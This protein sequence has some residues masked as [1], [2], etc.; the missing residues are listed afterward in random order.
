MLSVLIVGCGNIAGRFD[1]G[2][3]SAEWPVTHA[4]AYRKDG[5]FALA[6]CVDP[7]IARRQDFMSAWSIREGYGSVTE[8][9]KSGK[10]FDVVSICTPTSQHASDLETALALEP[11]AVFCEKPI[12]PSVEESEGIVRRYAE[13]G[14][15][16]G[17]N[18]NRRW[19]PTI[20]GLRD[21]IAQGGWG[22]LRSATAVYNKGL[23]NN[24]SH[25]LDLLSQL[26][27]PLEPIA[28]GPAISDFFETDP[29]IPACLIE[30][31]GAPIYLTCSHAADYSLFEFRLVFSEGSVSIE[32][33][34]ERWR[35]RRVMDSRRFAGY[36]VLDAGEFHDG[37][38]EKTMSLAVDN[39]YR[40][41]AAN[42]P[43]ASTGSTALAVQKLCEQI[44]DLSARAGDRSEMQ[45]VA[46]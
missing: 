38:D 37:G 28:A 21:E 35:V 34:G 5:R 23:L 17:V 22:T 26:L 45:G 39:L 3:P 8:L 9:V 40:N 24:G 15:A 32:D 46:K 25:M 31:S 4:G 6:G 10:T 43:L 2:R 30:K 44:R 33:G 41:V 19:D 36:R 12:T 29:T 18:Y 7:D 27:G 42:D 11:R 1:H 16:L 20:N 13:L 14:V